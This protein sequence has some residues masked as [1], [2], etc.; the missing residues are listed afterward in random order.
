M[1]APNEKLAD[2][3]SE[4]LTLQMAGKKAIRSSE[5]TR[6]VRERL[7][8]NGYLEEVM[9]GWY[10]PSQPGAKGETTAWYTSFWDFCRDYLNDRFGADWCLTPEQSLV[11]LAGNTAVPRQLLVRATRANNQPTNLLHGTSLFESNTRLPSEE[12]RT[13][14]NGLTLYNTEAALIAASPDFFQQYPVEARTLLSMQ[15]N[16]QAL[17]ARLLSGGHTRAAGR[18]A[19]AFTNIG[20]P[21][22]ASAIVTGMAAADHVVTETDPF[23][24]TVGRIP[25]RREPSPYVQRIRLMWQTL[26]TAIIDAMPAPPSTLLDIETYMKQVED[27]YVSDAYHSLSIEGY[28]VSADLIE[29]VRSGAW[30][31]QDDEVARNERNALAARGYWQAFQAVK[32]SVRRVLGGENPGDVANEDHGG[33]YQQLFQPSVAAGLI[34]PE[35]LAGYRTSP[36]YIRGSMHVP[37]KPEAVPDSMSIFFELLAEETDPTVR[38]VLGHFVYVYIHPYMD[39]NGRTGR[40]LM[41]V[42]LAAAGYPWL[43]IPVQA[44]A[45]YMA[46]LESASVG[47][48][49]RPFSA[50]LSRHMSAP[51]PPAV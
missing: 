9:K 30:N 1:P 26:R 34:K 44:R 49:I 28:Q 33:W 27:T 14:L 38:A 51:I 39:G 10:I 31:P 2:A 8:K 50:F 21:R 17:L 29:R 6:A 16:A 24:D 4:L 47:Q 13:V 3:L 18:L 32:A 46:A 12:D 43:V 22:E 48:D 11:L 40:F 19:G 15:S 41:N 20:R 36:V 37:L 23:A 7:S 35:S 45:D 5:L 42:M 25:Y